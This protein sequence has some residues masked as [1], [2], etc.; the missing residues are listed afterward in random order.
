MPRVYIKAQERAREEREK[1]KAEGYYDVRRHANF[2]TPEESR[3]NRL[4]QLKEGAKRQQARQKQAKEDFINE[5]IYLNMDLSETQLK[6]LV[7][8]EVREYNKRKKEEA[9]K[10]GVGRPSP[11]ETEEERKEAKKKWRKEG[12]KRYRER[13]RA[14]VNQKSRARYWAMSKKKKAERMQQLRD[15]YL[16]DDFR[17]RLLQYQLEYRLS[18]GTKNIKGETWLNYW[19]S[20]GARMNFV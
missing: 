4:A 1:K 6:A 20:R 8:E 11:F 10:R 15:R 17:T 16:D 9:K 7:R 3:A 2:D 5:I 19:E 13:N 18:N 14:E 12:G